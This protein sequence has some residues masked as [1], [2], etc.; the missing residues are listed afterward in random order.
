MKLVAF[1]ILLLFLAFPLSATSVVGT[2]TPG[3]CTEAA[4]DAAIAGRPLAASTLEPSPPAA[5][6]S[7]RGH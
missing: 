3:S 7:G 1:P 5:A 4:L 6:A 2:G